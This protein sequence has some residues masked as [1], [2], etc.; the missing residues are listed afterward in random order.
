MPTLTPSIQYSIEMARGL[1]R[2]QRSKMGRSPSSPQIHQKYIGMWNNS[3]RTPSEHWQKTPV[4]QKGK[5]QSSQNEIGQKIRIKRET[6]GFQTGICVPGK[7]WWRR[8]SVCTL[9]NPL[10][11]GDGGS[12][13]N[14][15]GNTATGAP[16]AKE[17]ELTTEITA[18]QHFPA[19]KRL[20]C[21]LWWKRAGWWGSGF[22]GR[23]SGEDQYW[24]LKIFWGRS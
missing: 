15:W 10:T 16:K 11:G 14:P 20:A 22:W 8:K 13:R 21:P 2:W 12:F 23:A 1:S 19:E 9:R 7:E 17:R 18:K 6:K 24:P 5:P 3:C 4:F